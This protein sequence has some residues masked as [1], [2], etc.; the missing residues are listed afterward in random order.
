M[1]NCTLH[2]SYYA[3]H[4]KMYHLVASNP[5]IFYSHD[6]YTFP[7][8]LS[9]AQPKFHTCQRTVLHLLH[10]PSSHCVISPC[11]CSS[12]RFTHVWHPSS[13]IGYFSGMTCSKCNHVIAWNVRI[14]FPFLEVKVLSF[15]SSYT[16]N[17]IY[18]I[19]L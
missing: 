17:Y 19:S 12:F 11:V 7:E 18:I 8:V 16:H 15:W 4:F 13:M 2:K 6:F 9:L 1:L 14:L 3:T 5:F 10:G